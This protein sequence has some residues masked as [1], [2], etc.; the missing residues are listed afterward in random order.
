MNNPFRSNHM[1]FVMF[2][3]R[4]INTLGTRIFRNFDIMTIRRTLVQARYNGK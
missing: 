1:K 4:G 3:L 2:I